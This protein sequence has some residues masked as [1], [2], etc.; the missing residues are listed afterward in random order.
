MMGVGE[1]IA[2]AWLC[3]GAGVLAG[4]WFASGLHEHHYQIRSGHRPAG[5]RLVVSNPHRGRR[6]AKR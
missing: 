2:G 6:G 4:F 3:F 1:L 5:P